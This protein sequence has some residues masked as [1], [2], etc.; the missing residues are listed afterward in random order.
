MEI[1]YMETLEFT[2]GGYTLIGTLHLPEPPRAPMVI[3]CH[4]LMAD[5]SSPKQVELAYACCR[6][7]IGYF[8]FDHRGCG[9]SQ[10]EFNRVTSLEGRQLDLMNAIRQVR[11]LDACNGVIGLFGSSMGGTVCLSVYHAENITAMVTVAAPLHSRFSHAEDHPFSLSFD[12]TAE[13]SRVKNILIFH[14]ECDE[15]VPISHARSLYA[16]ASHPKKVTIQP[17]GD[18]RMSDPD[19]QNAFIRQSVKWFAKSLLKGNASA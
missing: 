3:G 4:G 2:S 10:G 18:H 15:V 7:G 16:R 5:R 14:G 9:E 1:Y 11:S 13:A 8:R 17:C 19:H 12:I 6:Q